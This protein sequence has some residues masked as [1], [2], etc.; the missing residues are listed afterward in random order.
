MS[1]HLRDLSK[2]CRQPTPL[3]LALFVFRRILVQSLHSLRTMKSSSNNYSSIGSSSIPPFHRRHHSNNNSSK[4]GNLGSLRGSAFSAYSRPNQQTGDHHAHSY[5][6]AVPAPKPM[7]A[8]SAKVENTTSVH[9]TMASL[10][11]LDLTGKCTT[12]DTT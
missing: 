6:D 3:L 1:N 4:E 11:N 10:S 8:K 2:K 9:T 5:R 7:Q 12:I